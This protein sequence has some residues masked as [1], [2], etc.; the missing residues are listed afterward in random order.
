MT[1][2]VED[3]IAIRDHVVSLARSDGIWKVDGGLPELVWERARWVARFSSPAELAGN[4]R[5]GRGAP[6]RLLI[7]DRER[8]LFRAEWAE[9]GPIRVM[10]FDR[11][12]WEAKLLALPREI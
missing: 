4:V 6:N 5:S 12:A 3:A 9:D 2:R 10:I 7:T 11:G 1:T 8:V